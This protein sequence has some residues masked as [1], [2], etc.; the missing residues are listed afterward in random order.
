MLLDIKGF[1]D[2]GNLKY[3][4]GDSKSDLQ[5]LSNKLCPVR[6]ETNPN[7]FQFCKYNFTQT[8]LSSVKL[9]IGIIFV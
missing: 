8:F 7:E 2:S 6:D 1:F 5:F 3:S 9:G 4:I